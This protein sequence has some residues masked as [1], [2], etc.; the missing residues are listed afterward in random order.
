MSEAFELEASSRA[1]VGK[2]ASRRLRRLD[3][4]IPA[5]VYGGGKDPVSI[6][7]GHDDLWHH[8]ENEAFFSHIISLKVDGQPEEVLLKDL[9]RHPAKQQVMHAD[10]LRVTRGQAIVVN[11]PLH[12]INEEACPGVKLQGGRV[13]HSITELEIRCL[14]K[15]LPEYIEVDM[16]DAEL[17]QVVH[18]SDIKLPEGVE[19]VALSHGAE[20]DLAI[21]NIAQPKGLASDDEVEA[22]D[23]EAPEGEE[24]GDESEDNS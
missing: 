2:G 20:Q 15:D 8:L 17:G 6:T 9:Q 3:K 10:F 12:F 18:I 24:G 11:V 21:A 22:G 23:D 7:L 5:I 16:V 4:R 13:S 19:S 14:P 1:D